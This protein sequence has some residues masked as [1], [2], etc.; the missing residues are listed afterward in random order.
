MFLQGFTKGLQPCRNVF[1]SASFFVQQY[2]MKYLWSFLK[3]CKKFFWNIAENFH[4]LFV[5]S[6]NLPWNISEILWYYFSEYYCKPCRNFSQKNSRNVLISASFVIQKPFMKY[7]CK[8]SWKLVRNVFQ[9]LQKTFT[10]SSNNLKT[11]HEIFQK[12][13]GIIFRNI[14]V[15]HSEI[16]HTK[17]SEMFLCPHHFSFSNISWNISAKFLQNLY[18]IFSELLQKS[19][20]KYLYNPSTCH[21]I[22][23]QDFMKYLWNVSWNL[24]RNVSEI[25]QNNFK[26]N[27]TFF[28]FK[29]DS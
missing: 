23:R 6:A 24:L 14:T 22:F 12:C 27:C 16:F 4:E 3:T 10:N 8:V 26:K 13:C 15:N 18:E 2:F 21:E 19:F 17:I 28:T 11:W 25:L 29:K 7:F 5:Q 9:I 1:M 20:T